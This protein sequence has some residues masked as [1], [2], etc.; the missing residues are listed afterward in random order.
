MSKQTKLTYYGQFAVSI[1]CLTTRKEP[2]QS[3]NLFYKCWWFVV[4]STLGLL[5]HAWW[6]QT[7]M[8]LSICS[9]HLCLTTCK[10]LTQQLISFQ[11][12]GQFFWFRAL[13]TPKSNIFNSQI[14]SMYGCTKRL[15]KPLVSFQEYWQFVILKDLSTPNRNYKVNLYVSFV[16]NCM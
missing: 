8:K 9:F 16:S 2:T 3:F 11:T 13:T 7:K 1:G 12:Y 4:E 14:P 10:N 5:G 6:H 15:R